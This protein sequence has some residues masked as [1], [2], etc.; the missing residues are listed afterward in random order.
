MD[1]DA[2]FV[3]ESGVPAVFKPWPGRTESIIVPDVAKPNRLRFT[4]R[5]L[6]SHGIS[7]TRSD[8][9]AT[10][11]EALLKAT[12]YLDGALAVAH[13]IKSVSFGGR[14]M[15]DGETL[16]AY[17]VRATSQ[18]RLDKAVLDALTVTLGLSLIHI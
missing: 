9:F 2:V 13:T 8:S 10:V 6:S 15:G 12:P 18:G 14:E 11:R 5:F 16:A 1:I 4:H 17:E 3:L 7:L